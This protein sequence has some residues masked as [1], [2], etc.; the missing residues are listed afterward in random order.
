MFRSPTSTHRAWARSPT[1]SPPSP[2]SPAI[3]P[4]AGAVMSSSSSRINAA[5][6]RKSPPVARKRRTSRTRI[7]RSSFRRRRSRSWTRVGSTTVA[8]HRRRFGMA[9]WK[10]PTSASRSRRRPFS[11]PPR[12][13]GFS[14]ASKPRQRP[15]RSGATPPEHS[16]SVWIHRGCRPDSRNPGRARATRVSAAATTALPMLSGLRSTLSSAAKA[17]RA[18]PRSPATATASGRASPL[19]HCRRRPSSLLV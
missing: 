6:V 10:F 3:A 18:S 11:A 19:K 4:C 8:S 15:G 14:T 1:I 7:S 13:S 2:V 16:T 12:N 9:S 17:S 5:T